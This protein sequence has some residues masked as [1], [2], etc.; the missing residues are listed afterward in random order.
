MANCKDCLHY[1]ACKSFADH[2]GFDLALW[3][4]KHGLWCSGDHFKD[5]SRFVEITDDALSLIE[6]VLDTLIEVGNGTSE[7]ELHEAADKMFDLRDMI[8]PNRERKEGE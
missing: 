1:E 6:D 4:D 5:R 7:D 8:T 2:D 3:S